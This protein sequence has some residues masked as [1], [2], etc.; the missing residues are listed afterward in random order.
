MVEPF[1]PPGSR[2]TIGRAS[3]AELVL[4]AASIIRDC[5][6]QPNSRGGLG[7]EFSEQY[8]EVG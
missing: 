5:V 4:G 3:T 8:P 6:D 1:I 7:K 2:S